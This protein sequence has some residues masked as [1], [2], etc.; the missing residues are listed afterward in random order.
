M[1]LILSS[2]KYFTEDHN[3]EIALT[4]STT[5]H[6]TATYDISEKA[7]SLLKDSS[8]SLSSEAIHLLKE[9]S[10]DSHGLILSLEYL[11]GSEISTNDKQIFSGDDPRQLAI[12]HEAIESLESFGL[13]V[14]NSGKRESFSITSKGYSFTDEVNV[15]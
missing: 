2:H 5:Q 3:S 10:L 11:G 15:K 4:E 1:S 6:Q 8:V 9:A 12:W 14:D 13:I 7:I